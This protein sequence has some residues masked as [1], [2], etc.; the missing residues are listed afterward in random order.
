MTPKAQRAVLYLVMGVAHSTYIKK[1]NLQEEKNIKHTWIQKIQNYLFSTR[2]RRGLSFICFTCIIIF[3]FCLSNTLFDDPI[4]TAIYSND[5]RLLNAQIATDGQWRFAELDSV[6]DRFAIALLCYEDKRFYHHFG[7]DPIAVGR[8]IKQNIANQKVVSGAS[9]LTMQLMR[10]SRKNRS[11]NIL[12][13]IIESIQALR[14]EIRYNKEEILSMYASHAPFGGNVV[15]L[16]AASWRYFGRSPFDL[17]WAESA[18]LAV[19]PNQPSVIHPGRN[20]NALRS[21]RNNLLSDLLKEKKI[22]KLEYDAALL[23]DVPSQPKPIP[24]LATHLLQQ[25]KK[26]GPQEKIVT[27]IEYDIQQR[28][29]KIVNDHYQINIQNDIHNAA[30][31]IIENK[32][33]NVITYVGNTESGGHEGSVDM[34]QAERSSGSILKPLLYASMIDDR[35]LTPHMLVDDIP[36]YINGYTPKNYHKRFSGAVSASD[37]LSRSLNVPSV[38]MLQDY[39]IDKFQYKLEQYGVS[40]LHYT[41][42]HYGLPLILG[43]AEVK[44]WDLCNIYSSMSRTLENYYQTS[45]KYNANDWRESSISENEQVEKNLL[46]VPSHMSA[47]AIY[48]TFEAMQNLSRPTESGHWEQFSSSRRLAWKTGTS[49]GHRDAWAVGCTKDY[50]IGIWAGNADGE[51][52]P[53][54]VGVHL[55]GSLLFEILNVLP[56]EDR[57]FYEPIDDMV[58]AHMCK[59]SGHLAGA[60]CT[61]I[62]TVRIPKRSAET[63]ACP[64]H[65]KIHLDPSLRYQVDAN[66][67]DQSD[68]R[69]RSWF[70]LSPE[71]AA[72]YRQSHSDYQRL[73]GMHPRCSSSVAQD[74]Q[75]SLV[76]PHDDASI[77]IPIDIDGSRQQTIAKA[78]HQDDNSTLY[79]H[80][81]GHYLGSTET[82]HTMSIDTEMGA[83]VLVV[84]DDD[85]NRV[86]S[87]F[88]VMSR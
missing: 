29:Q 73:P 85:G 72:Y 59:E 48:V 44:L 79:W 21:K 23:E 84:V 86:S 30:V 61:E 14:T 12:Q 47:S 74:Q 17:S 70:V 22:T 5:G 66:C 49:Y 45:N 56:A 36:S 62:D 88:D 41:A 19:L 63:S 35:M 75:V 40:T 76:Y 8:A 26:I 24:R 67:I 9:T 34:I 13:K 55:A 80:L 52:R 18:T 68:I 50:T 42:D 38:L 7:I 82:F 51:G 20:R 3:T 69:S 6:P 16:E 27:K 2:I 31:L 43:G 39:G 33:G 37:A 65:K 64:Y 46:F 25:L 10:M 71:V 77:Y 54:I 28:A 11:R 57:W 58:V 87:T 4:S 60:N 1:S 32:T 83:H 15:G 53:G 78:T 81:D